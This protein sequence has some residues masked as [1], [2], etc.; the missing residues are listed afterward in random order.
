LW[1]VRV[2]KKAQ[3]A[4]LLK[5]NMYEEHYK[6]KIYCLNVPFHTLHIRRNGIPSWNGNTPAASIGVITTTGQL[7]L[8]D[9]LVT[10]DMGAVNFSRLLKEKLSH[11]YPIDTV[12]EVYGDPAGDQR[13]QV[14]ESTPFQIIREAG[15][16]AWPTHTNDPVIRRE[17]VAE[18]L[19]RLSF[20]GKPGLVVTP[21]AKYTRRAFSGGYKYKR[22]QVKGD[23]R[24]TDK[25]DKN[26]FSHI[27]DA[28]QYLV[29]GAVGDTDVIGGYDKKELDYSSINRGIV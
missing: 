8:L 27:S 29:L 4:E 19:T 9:E 18:K 24:Y 21:K 2:K 28:V 12:F 20:D 3:R 25:P 17:V 6:G 16:D 7:I 14:D 15:I 26:K 5:K 1:I 11:D 23:E 22:V 13:S 10:F